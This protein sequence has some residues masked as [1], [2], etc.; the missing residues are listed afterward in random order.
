MKDQPPS[1][2]TPFPFV[3]VSNIFCL[4]S[5]HPGAPSC[6]HCPSLFFFLSHIVRTCPSTQC[7]LNI[8]WLTCSH[9]LSSVSSLPAP[10]LFMLTHSRPRSP[11]TFPLLTNPVSNRKLNTSSPELPLHLM[12]LY[13]VSYTH[14]TLPTKLS[15]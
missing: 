2:Y 4:S 12:C 10:L 13:P 9:G 3:H 7:T 5:T 15:V 6:S 1:H 11:F 14:L 8:I